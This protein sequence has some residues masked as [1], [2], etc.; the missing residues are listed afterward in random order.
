MLL[1]VLNSVVDQLGVLGL[2]GGGEDERGVGGGILR[3]VLL[4]CYTVH[5][6]T[7]YRCG[8][9]NLLLKSP[10]SQTTVCHRSVKAL[11]QGGKEVAYGAGSF[12]LVERGSHDCGRM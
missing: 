3:L 5:V 1:A 8:W 6:S 10:E 4:D 7:F 12:E 9:R 2:L 11:G